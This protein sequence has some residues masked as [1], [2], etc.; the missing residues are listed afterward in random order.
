M[1]A[2]P[3]ALPGALRGKALV[4]WAVGAPPNAPGGARA[5]SP[6]FYV[7]WLPGALVP[8]APC[9][10][11]AARLHGLLHTQIVDETKDQGSTAVG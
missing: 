6:R 7:R 1:P 3:C 5:T 10:H 11:A 4:K 8:A 9:A 2:G